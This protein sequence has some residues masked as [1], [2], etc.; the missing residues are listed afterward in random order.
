MKFREH[1]GTLKDSLETT[2]ELPPVRHVLAS[3]LSRLRGRRIFAADLSMADD[4]VWDPR[5]KWETYT[6]LWRG[7]AIG[8][9]DEPFK[10]PTK[11]FASMSLAQQ[12]V[13]AA[14]GGKTIAKDRK[15]MSK[16]GRLSRRNR[17]L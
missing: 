16:I 9:A 6:V 12:R 7:Q 4:H 8:F 15:H 10:N 17:A 3:Y 13:I 2:V 1:R 5:T 11:G 14:S